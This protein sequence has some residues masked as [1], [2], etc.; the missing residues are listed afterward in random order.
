METVGRG[1]LDL[2][3]RPPLEVVRKWK[4]FR[5]QEGWKWKPLFLP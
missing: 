4:G 2:F 1:A 5:L 3:L